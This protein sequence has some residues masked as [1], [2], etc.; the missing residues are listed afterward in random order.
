[1]SG[2]ADAFK[3]RINWVFAL[4]SFLKAE[5]FTLVAKSMGICNHNA[6]MKC[7]RALNVLSIKCACKADILVRKEELLGL[8]DNWRLKL[9][10]LSEL[11]GKL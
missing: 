7:Y 2:R 10:D 1:M 8:I 5:S 9:I 6:R 3:A 4:E 11:E